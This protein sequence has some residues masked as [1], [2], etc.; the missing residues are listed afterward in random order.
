MRTH[1]PRL[2]AGAP[3]TNIIRHTLARGGTVP[4]ARRVYLTRGLADDRI[5]LR[6]GTEPAELGP[7]QVDDL[8]RALY[9]WKADR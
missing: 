5:E 9:I 4:I 2:G 7:R 3:P 1:P 6:V 8:I